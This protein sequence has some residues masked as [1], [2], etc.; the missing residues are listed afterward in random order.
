M[1]GESFAKAGCLMTPSSTTS[2]TI[3]CSGNPYSRKSL[4]LTAVICWLLPP[5]S[6]LARHARYMT[7]H[8]MYGSTRD[9]ASQ[10]VPC[11]TPQP[12]S[13]SLLQ[14]AAK[15]LRATS[16]AGP[17]AWQMAELQSLPDIF[18]ALWLPFMTPLSTA[19][20]G[21]QRGLKPRSA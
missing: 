4:M 9:L 1:K 7:M 14:A 13:C 16:A 2:S 20:L 5:R 10:T 19:Q 11:M 12:W 21:P 17:D 8:V 6:S 15:K 3:D 18:A